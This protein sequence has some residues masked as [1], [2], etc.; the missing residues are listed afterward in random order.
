MG[1]KYRVMHIFVQELKYK[2]PDSKIHALKEANAQ[3]PRLILA[4]P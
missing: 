2:I 1:Y 3:N 4:L